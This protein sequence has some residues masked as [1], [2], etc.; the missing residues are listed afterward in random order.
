MKYVNRPF[1]LIHSSSDGRFSLITPHEGDMIVYDS[2]SNKWVNLSSAVPS[3]VFGPALADTSRIYISWE[4]VRQYNVGFLPDLLPLIRS[5]T[6]ELYIPG[7]LQVLTADT[8]HL[9]ITGL[10]LTFQTPYT[11]TFPS[12]TFP[13]ETT[14]RNVCLFSSASL[15]GLIADPTKYLSMWYSN[16]QT[17]ENKSILYLPSFATAGVPSPPR[18]LT[19]SPITGTSITLNYDAPLY[20]DSIAMTT[21]PA[22]IDGYK[23]TY[24]TSG[25]S[26]RYG[27]P[28]AQSLQTDFYG[29]L[30][31]HL[32]SSIYPDSTYDFSVYAKN[33][34]N[35]SY[36][37]AL[38]G[39]QST[40]SLAQPP[41]IGSLSFP[42]RFVSSAYAVSDTSATPTLITNLTL[43]N[44]DWTS[45]SS[46]MNIN[47]TATRG[48]LGSGN[49]MA[50]DV[51]TVKNAATNSGPTVQFEGFPIT[52]SSTSTVNNLT[53]TPSINTDAYSGTGQ[54]GFFL[55][56][57]MT[58]TIGSALFSAS[59]HQTVFTATQTPG[60]A[61]TVSYY[62]D[63]TAS[64][65]GTPTVSWNISTATAT[66]I[67]GVYVINGT[68]S[69]SVSSVCSAMGTYF[70]ASP[71][72]KYD[73]SLG[74]I[75][76]TYSRTN[77]NSGITGTFPT[78]TIADT[79]T[80]S[81]LNGAFSIAIGN[82]SLD[83]LT[84]KNP[85]GSTPYTGTTKITSVVDG[86][87]VSLLFTTLPQNLTA[88]TTV[89][90]SFVIGKRCYSGAVSYLTYLPAYAFGTTRYST[91][92]YN[93]ALLLT[94][95]PGAGVQDQRQEL[96]VCGGLFR[97]FDTNYGF[98][99]Y[100]SYKYSSSA[101]NTA[102][103]SALTGMRFST[104]VWQIAN[105]TNQYTS[106]AFELHGLNTTPT[107]AG[108]VASLGGSQIQFL[109]RV[110]DSTSA[111]AG[112]PDASQTY[113]TGNWCDAMSVNGLSAPVSAA[114]YSTPSTSTPTD[115]KGGMD[116]GAT[117]SGGVLT[118]PVRFPSRPFTVS[119]TNIV[120]YAR[121]GIPF[122]AYGFTYPKVKIS[123]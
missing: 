98:K 84:L 3:V 78:P 36:S 62:Y 30:L 107:I 76:G 92:D 34:L 2:I 37:T 14:P 123:T 27:G 7:L 31:T 47:T 95:T 90:G 72:A 35:A 87:S 15:A 41:G 88:A 110:E 42:N 93:N 63:S 1:S 91:L 113:I 9:N 117:Y 17:Y 70:W 77:I 4:P 122:G 102:N 108:G 100:T 22:N 54:T 112:V 16:Y 106:M 29:A 33:D 83:T 115:I 24:E 105:S 79:I 19:Y 60:S 82:M 38:T 109:Y 81:S 52:T 96:Q 116:T 65:P 12:I 49:L 71:L 111:V 43:T 94:A 73:F 97:N 121:I 56:A 57:N 55:N 89:D 44:T 75:T 66:Q 103:Y 13:N 8:A 25:S 10:V 59:Q 74:S 101:F 85:Y 21:S 26:I 50:V 86:P 58:F 104:F 39:S 118:I 120:L 99:D 80:S 46:V 28:V 64:S 18:N 40:S 114:N 6:Q 11:T 68:P 53:I 51:K 20:T 67:S 48:T 119:T 5:L 23:A 32:V 45:S 69:M 61:S